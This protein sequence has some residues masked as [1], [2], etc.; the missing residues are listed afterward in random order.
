MQCKYPDGQAPAQAS[1]RLTI[2]HIRNGRAR[3]CLCLSAAGW[4]QNGTW[5]CGGCR[6]APRRAAARRGSP[7]PAP[8]L[9]LQDRLG[10]IQGVRVVRTQIKARRGSPPPVPRP[11]LHAKTRKVW[12][13]VYAGS[14]CQDVR[15]L[16]VQGLRIAACETARRCPGR[17]T[18][19]SVLSRQHAESEVLVLLA[20]LTKC[21]DMPHMLS[22]NSDLQTED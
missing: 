14:A 12:I 10:G 19:T 2:T 7:P 5:R 4:V 11:G 15:L 3:S 20:A 13:R 18:A 16:G 1:C 22:I 9:G 17:L 8:R 21:K 6:P